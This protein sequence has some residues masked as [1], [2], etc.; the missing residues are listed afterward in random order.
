M[1]VVKTNKGCISSVPFAQTFT[2]NVKPVASFRSA[3]QLMFAN[4]SATFNNTTTISDGTL[5]A[6][7]YLWN[8]GDGTGNVPSPPNNPTHIYTAVG[9]FSVKLIATSNNGC[10]DDTTDMVTNGIYAA[11]VAAFAP[12]A[13]K[14]C[15]SDSAAFTDL[16]TPSTG[17]AAVNQWQWDFG[18]TFTSGLQNPKHKYS[19]PGT[20]TVTLIVKSA[21][22][23][24]SLPVTRTIIIDT[25]PTADFTGSSVK[26]EKNNIAF[27]D[28]SNGR[29]GNLTEW[30][31]SLVMEL[32]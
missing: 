22:G 1:L 6:V 24:F 11:P 12:L 27:T 23:C 19:N 14:I 10:I 7:T 3:G 26:C 5:G 30:H 25:L 32:H 28:A 17:T 13:A 29:G 21:S 20:Y 4:P 2:I 31:W 9:P 15:L 16:S 8:F 18:D